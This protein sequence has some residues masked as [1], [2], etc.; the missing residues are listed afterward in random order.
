MPVV[1][2]VTA[3]NFHLT[4][5]S[6]A[7]AARNVDTWEPR[8]STFNIVT[9]IGHQKMSKMWDVYTMNMALMVEP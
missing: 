1:S 8:G 6:W 5:L 2:L 3:Y 9:Y 4:L 7:W